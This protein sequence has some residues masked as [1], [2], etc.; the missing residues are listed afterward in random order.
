M[1]FI[2]SKT[3]KPINK[4][5]FKDLTDEEL[6]S[7]YRIDEDTNCIG[8]LFERYTHLVFGLCMKYLK[9]ADES[10]DAVM[11]VFEKLHTELKK[12]KIEHWKS[13]L[14][15]VAK[16]HCL[17][18]I[19]KQDMHL[20]HRD[21]IKNES[22]IMEFVPDIHLNIENKPDASQKIAEALTELNKDQKTCIELFYLQ[23]KSYKEISDITGFD[24]KQVKS[25]L[26]N[27]KRNLKI[28]LTEKKIN[29]EDFAWCIVLFLTI[30]SLNTFYLN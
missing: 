30:E 1:L 22:E 25:F 17:M 12:Q 29:L 20:N 2:K 23:E 7:K 18:Q 26:Q 21:A 27:G 16:N 28:I 6:V 3:A 15:M 4:P 8:E 9:N 19:R 10:K 11:Q 5:S 24:D 14:Y 13:W